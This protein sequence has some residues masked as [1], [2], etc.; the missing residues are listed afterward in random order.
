MIS[1]SLTEQSWG[2][3]LFMVY[4]VC[5]TGAAMLIETHIQ[6]NTQSSIRASIMSLQSTLSRL[7]SLPTALLL[8]WV[9]RQYDIFMSIKLVGA[10]ATVLL[11]FWVTIGAKHLTV[12]EAANKLQN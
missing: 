2:L 1:F 7:A 3:V 5:N 10:M 11:V 9:A 6:H 4:A 12:H 8:G